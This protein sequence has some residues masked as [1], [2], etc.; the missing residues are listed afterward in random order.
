V[1]GLAIAV[2]VSAAPADWSVTARWLDTLGCHELAVEAILVSSPTDAAARATVAD[3]LMAAIALATPGDPQAVR[4]RIELQRVLNGLDRMHAHLARVALLADDRALAMHATGDTRRD[5]LR[6]AVQTAQLE[7]MDLEAHHAEVQDR[8]PRR[9]LEALLRRVLLIRGLMLVDLGEQTSDAAASLRA[10]LLD[11]VDPG[12]DGLHDVPS[13]VLE[14]VDGAWAAMALA[15]LDVKQGRV[16][17][18]QA[19]VDRLI[20]ADAPA[21]RDT[22]ASLVRD[23]LLAMP[24]EIRMDVLGEWA[25][26]LHVDTLFT[27]LRIAPGLDPQVIPLLIARGARGRVVD[28]LAA[29]DRQLP[30]SGGAVAALAALR[31]AQLDRLSYSQAATLIDGAI[32]ADGGGDVELQLALARV[33]LETGA[34]AR[35]V[36]VSLAIGPGAHKPQADAVALLAMLQRAKAGRPDGSIG[37]DPVLRVLLER[38]A[39]R[40][41]DAPLRHVAALRLAAMPG[42]DTA[43]ALSLLA[44]IPTD[45]TQHTRAVRLREV[46]SWRAWHAAETHAE[47]VV[48]ASRDVLDLGGPDA[49]PAADRLLAVVLQTRMDPLE[50]RV[51]T[52]RAIQAI[53]AVRG[54]AAGRAA[55]ASFQR[56]A[57]QAATAM[58]IV[59]NAWSEGL[60]SPHLIRVARELLETPTSLGVGA[61][62]LAS[63]V[64]GRPPIAMRLDALT[65]DDVRIL[66]H[67]ARHLAHSGTMTMEE[68]EHAAALE[69]LDQTGL[70]AMA[71]QAADDELWMLSVRAWAKAAGL[72]GAVAGACRLQQAKALAH[73]DHAAAR[74]LAGQLSV[75]HAGT[76]L[77]RAAAALQAALNTRA[78]NGA[79]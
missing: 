49:A 26:G 9:Q 30:A 11:G 70:M 33:L 57:G 64:M 22:G 15:R 2:V 8:I 68:L 29:A 60:R 75:L 17:A 16:D 12:A 71:R 53:T 58:A 23:V 50:V 77:G 74:D 55:E 47:D 3:G 63:H 37:S 62:E 34:Y 72:G 13:A 35:S 14:S 48:R 46:V 52:E 40:G 66:R 10:A 61:T 78:E 45:S 32:A 56:A 25:T 18:A 24:P 67:W 41:D 69:V 51:L 5:L 7:Q 59:L 79:P 54:D 31:R 39:T 65:A 44:S 28:V 73:V 42:T 38:M 6:G 43:E 1:I 19:W 21:L 4:A 36:D 27:L 20:A 76:E